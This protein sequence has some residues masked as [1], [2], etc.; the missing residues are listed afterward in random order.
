MYLQTVQGLD[1]SSQEKAASVSDRHRFDRDHR[2]SDYPA[3]QALVP[4]AGLR[5]NASVFNYLFFWS[6][7]TNIQANALTGLL[8]V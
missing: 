4:P 5:G 6:V 2:C 1:S 8:E 3:F 7:C